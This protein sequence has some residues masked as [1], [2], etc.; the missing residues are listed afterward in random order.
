MER[1]IREITEGD[2]GKE[3]KA[4]ADKWKVLAKKS[5]DEG[6]SSDKI[7]DEFVAKLK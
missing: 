6:G 2:K 3:F 4:N 5:V 7:I 1:C